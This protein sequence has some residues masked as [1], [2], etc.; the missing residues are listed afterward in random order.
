[1]ELPVT[2][3]QMQELMKLAGTEPGKKLLSMLQHQAGPELRRALSQK[4]YEKVKVI[5]KEFMKDPNVQKL[6]REL[7]Q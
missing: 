6:L 7:G 2:P 3:Q 5:I 1:M 4:N